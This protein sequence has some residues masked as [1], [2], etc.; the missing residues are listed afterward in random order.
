M[1]YMLLFD[2]TNT[3]H[4]DMLLATIDDSLDALRDW[5]IADAHIR[6]HSNEK[7]K[8]VGIKPRD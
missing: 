5:D 4:V 8:I 7:V 2:E 3:V 1:V 6:Y